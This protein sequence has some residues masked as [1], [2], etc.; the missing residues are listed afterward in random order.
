MTKLTLSLVIL[1]NFFTCI[2]YLTFSLFRRQCRV[3][4]RVQL[5]VRGF[6]ARRG[7]DLPAAGEPA[8][9]PRRCAAVGGESV[10]NAV[11]CAQA[12][13]LIRIHISK[14]LGPNPLE[15]NTNLAWIRSYRKKKCG[16]SEKSYNEI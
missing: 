7:D 4:K 2:L 5:Q 11:T 10:Y 6:G 12:V 1:N 3:R 14:C 8:G 9:I 16:K 13:Y 15:K